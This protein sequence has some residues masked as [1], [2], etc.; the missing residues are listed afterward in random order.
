VSRSLCSSP[1]RRAGDGRRRFPES[2]P[3]SPSARA[4]RGRTQSIHVIAH[5]QE[6]SRVLGPFG[7][8]LRQNGFSRGSQSGFLPQR[9]P[10]TKSP[11]ACSMA[12]S[13]DVSGTS[14]V[15]SAGDG[16]SDGQAG[17]LH[18]GGPAVHRGGD[19]DQDQPQP[20]RV[21]DTAGP[22]PV[23][24]CSHPNTTATGARLEPDTSRSPR[25]SCTGHLRASVRARIQLRTEA[26]TVCVDRDVRKNVQFS[27]GAVVARAT[28]PRP[29]GDG[30]RT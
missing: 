11:N 8:Q 18:Q 20:D 1:L 12:S 30:A 3:G 17:G 25:T 28:V 29:E 13:Q 22:P 27:R 23:G 2:A 15:E 10:P 6:S 21:T 5:G 26:R 9:T 7:P 24:G 19:E 14:V 16:E 4:S